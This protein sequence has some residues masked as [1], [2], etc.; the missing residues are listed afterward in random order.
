VEIIPVD[1]CRKN[2][3]FLSLW[4][5]FGFFK[6]GCGKKVVAAVREKSLFH[7]FFYYCCYYYLKYLFISIYLLF[8]G[9]KG[10]VH[11]FYL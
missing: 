6:N 7:I 3:H 5:K 11:A 10:F 8:S 2:F 1:I 4:K 9:K